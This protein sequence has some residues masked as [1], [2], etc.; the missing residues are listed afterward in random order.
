MAKC[1]QLYLYI[2]VFITVVIVR[3][4]ALFL[5]HMTFDPGGI[6]DHCQDCSSSYSVLPLNIH[7]VYYNISQIEISPELK[8]AQLSWSLMNK[9]FKYTLWNESMVEQL[10]RDKYPY[11]ENLYYSY[12]RWIH[13]I[14]M[15]RYII[16]HQHGGIYADIDIECI[17][18]MLDIYMSFPVNTGVVMYYTKPFGVSNDF[19]IAKAKH[20][21]MTAVIR[22][23]SSSNRWYVLPFLTEMFSTGP[24]YL[25]ARFWSFKNRY[26]MIVLQDTQSFLSHRTGESWHESDAKLIWWIFL[27]IS[28]VTKWIV[29]ITAVFIFV[30][31]TYKLWKP[32]LCNMGIIMRFRNTIYV[33]KA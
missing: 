30:Y 14:D 11:L 22:G 17:K 1:Y 32:F 12:E 10:L 8:E 16:L 25:S 13:K 18:N 2:L 24:V 27:N 26:D 7:Q 31:C 9:A 4:F 33:R 20:P 3:P 28:I 19:I 21:F 23:L 6:N 15:A 29:V 5:M